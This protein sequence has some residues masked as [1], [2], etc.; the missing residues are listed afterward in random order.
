MNMAIQEL[1]DRILV[2]RRISRTDQNR[3]MS[4]LLAKNSLSTEDQQ[5]ITRVFDG[6][7]TGLIRVVD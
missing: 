5:Q 1:A 4:A 6:L 3:F 2:S 7:Q